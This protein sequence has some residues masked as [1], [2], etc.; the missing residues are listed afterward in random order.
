MTATHTPPGTRGS[1]YTICGYTVSNG[2]GVL[3]NF[4]RRQ[5]ESAVAIWKQVAEDG[6]EL[7]AVALFDS[8]FGAGKTAVMATWN[9]FT[10]TWSN[11]R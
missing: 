4:N 10:E 5:F 3:Q 6:A 8:P 1:D 11:W 9:N 7:H 2:G